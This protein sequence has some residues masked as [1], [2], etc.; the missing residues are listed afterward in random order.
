MQG[1]WMVSQLPS[2]LQRRYGSPVKPMAQLPEEK[3]PDPVVGQSASP[4][5]VSGQVIPAPTYAVD[6]HAA[7][8]ARERTAS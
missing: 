6:S 8:L 4:S 5:F 2:S 7:A 3:S 1:F